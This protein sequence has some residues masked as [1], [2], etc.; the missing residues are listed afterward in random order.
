MIHINY[1][2]C[3]HLSWSLIILIALI[4]WGVWIVGVG[5]GDVVRWG[6]DVIGWRIDVIG[7]RIDVIGWRIDVIGWR[8]DVVIGWNIIIAYF[9]FIWINDWIINSVILIHISHS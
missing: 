7:W 9:S 8:I 3:F 6:R 2:C 1:S 4:V 5:C